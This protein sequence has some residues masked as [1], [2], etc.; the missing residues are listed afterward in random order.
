MLK[1][2]GILLQKKNIL[3]TCNY[4][5]HSIGKRRNDLITHLLTGELKYPGFHVNIPINLNVDPLSD[6]L[7]QTR[8]LGKSR[9]WKSF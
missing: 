1:I 5:P 4:I 3:S 6:Q 7:S 9:V 8:D 2:C